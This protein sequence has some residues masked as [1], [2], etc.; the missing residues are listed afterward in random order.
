MLKNSFD[1]GPLS[2]TYYAICILSG[3]I[4]AY[5]IGVKLA[6]K[7]GIDKDLI[8]DGLIYCVPLSII[9]ARIYYVIFEWDYYKDDFFEVF[10]V[11]EGGLAIHG[12]I[13]TAIIFI[14]VYC[15]IRKLNIWSVFDIVFPGFMLAQALGRFGNFYNCEAHGDIM[16]GWLVDVE[17]FFLPDAFLDRYYDYL[18]S[19]VHPTFIYEALLNVLGFIIVINLRKLKFF[20]KGDTLPFYMIW[21]GIIRFF[22]EGLR[23]DSLMAE[24]FGHVVKQ[25]QVISIVLIILGVALFIV[26]R[27]VLKVK[28]PFSDTITDEYEVAPSF[29]EMAIKPEETM[30]EYYK[31]LF[32]KKKE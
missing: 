29:S 20:K 15:K 32:K 17:K 13:I 16:P 30:V 9:G 19:Y 14:L 23:T 4:V 11:W 24:Y 8:F 21:Y 5:L 18:G 28:E 22:I 27:F 7:M 10:K 2:I 1:I 12:G 25:N 3:V 6:K 31:N 26:K